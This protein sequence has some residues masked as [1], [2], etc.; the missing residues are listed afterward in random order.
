MG[1]ENENKENIVIFNCKIDSTLR[2]NF[3]I[4]TIKDQTTM[5]DVVIDAI[6][7]YVGE[8]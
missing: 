7:K 6:K 3:K 8:D 1:E 5:A 2:D 4:K